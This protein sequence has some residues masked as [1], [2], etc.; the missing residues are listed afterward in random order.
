MQQRLA[1][2]MA[3]GQAA[4]AVNVQAPPGPPQ[5]GLVNPGAL[6]PRPPSLMD[7][8]IELLHRPRYFLNL[9]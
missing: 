6:A 9:L 8:L 1:Q 2:I 4:G 5:P 7:H 3:Q